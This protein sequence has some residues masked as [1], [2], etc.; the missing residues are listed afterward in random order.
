MSISS[1]SIQVKSA[2]STKCNF[3]EKTMG[4]IVWKLEKHNEE[5]LRFCFMT[6]EVVEHKDYLGKEAYKV[7]ARSDFQG[8]VVEN[9]VFDLWRLE[10]VNFD[11]SRISKCTF[12]GDSDDVLEMRNLALTES[13][14]EDCEFVNV[15]IVKCYMKG[16]NFNKC[17]FTNC[18]IKGTI[19][20]CTDAI[21]TNCIFLGT[22]KEK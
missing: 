4:F 14:F 7:L 11:R 10:G 3:I 12:R 20:S 15:L 18:L 22:L 5:L 13:H 2:K 9:L 17:K 21:F 1:F 8:K 19:Y 6:P 16:T